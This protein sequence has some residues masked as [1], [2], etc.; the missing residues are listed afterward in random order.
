MKCAIIAVQKRATVATRGCESYRDSLKLAVSSFPHALVSVIRPDLLIGW[1]FQLGV[2]DNLH[3]PRM[4]AN[5]TDI[6][7]STKTVANLKPAVKS[8]LNNLTCWLRAYTLHI[9]LNVAKTE[10]MII[11]SWQRCPI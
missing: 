1:K 2:S 6:A 5:D 9:S 4:F 7:F 3:M 11:G 8:E 10:L